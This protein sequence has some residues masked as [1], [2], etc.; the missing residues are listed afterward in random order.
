MNCAR[1]PSPLSQPCSV[2]RPV[3]KYARQ[4]AS[5]SGN[6]STVW[7]N[8]GRRN[9]LMVSAGTLPPSRSTPVMASHRGSRRVLKPP[10]SRARDWRPSAATTSRAS[11]VS[12]PPRASA[13]TDGIGPGASAVTVTPRRTSAQSRRE[14]V[15]RPAHHP[16]PA[17]VGAPPER[18]PVER[19]LAHVFHPL[20]LH[21]RR[22]EM[23]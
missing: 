21:Q 20:P 2:R 18:V 13:S 11:R 6:S 3:Q 17:P 15:S 7:P 12:D 4:R 9:T 22:P 10:H 16:Y 14:A 19:A 5:S 8:T 1:F 23:L